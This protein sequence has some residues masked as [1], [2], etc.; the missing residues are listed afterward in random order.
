MKARKQPGN[1]PN[2]SERDHKFGQRAPAGRGD[3]FLDVHIKIMD[4]SVSKRFYHLETVIAKLNEI[5]P[6][7]FVRGGDEKRFMGNPK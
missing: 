3:R 6:A 4:S 2:K 7:G 1:K 5:A